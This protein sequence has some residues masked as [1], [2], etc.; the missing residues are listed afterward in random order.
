MS[1]AHRSCA[2]RIGPYAVIRAILQEYKLLDMLSRYFWDGCGFLLDTAYYMNVDE[3]NAG[4]YY[5]D[6]AFCHPLF[7]EGIQIYSNSKV[8]RFMNLVT[9]DQIRGFLNE[10]NWKRDHRQRI[11]IFYDSSNKNCQRVTSILLNAA[12]PKITEVS[13][14]LICR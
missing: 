6:F 1:E 2:L 9:K 4:Q 10:W 14:Y 12:R 11:Y 3:E 7:S 13:R 5:P 8:S